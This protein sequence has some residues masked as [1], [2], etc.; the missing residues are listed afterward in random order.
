[1]TKRVILIH[2]GNLGETR[3]GLYIGRTDA[4]LSEGGRRQAAALAGSSD[5]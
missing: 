2:H 1:M 3:R 5:G 4:P